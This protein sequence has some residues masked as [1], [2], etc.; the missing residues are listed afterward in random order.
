[1]KAED[2]VKEQEYYNYSGEILVLDGLAFS[3]L[4]MLGGKTINIKGGLLYSEV[5]S[6]E[7]SIK[8]VKL[9]AKNTSVAEENGILKVLLGKTP[10]FYVELDGKKTSEFPA[11]PVRFKTLIFETQ[12]V[13]LE[14][15]RPGTLRYDSHR[16]RIDARLLP[17]GTILYSLP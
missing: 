6:Y 8:G 5:Q 1:V 7:K 2:G 13:T 15:K 10:E 12:K 4:S 3:E 16:I 11:G 14:V 9:S 17:P